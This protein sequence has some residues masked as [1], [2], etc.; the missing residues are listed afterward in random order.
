MI[1]DSD[2]PE[3]QRRGLP[4]TEDSL[5]Q[6]PSDRLKSDLRRVPSSG[7]RDS[8][9]TSCCP[10]CGLPTI[11]GPHSSDA[12]CVDA[13]GAEIARITIMLLDEREQRDRD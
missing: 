8:D 11:D 1:G 6:T 4:E 3:I 12:A 7:R 5:A 10:S 9:P 2:S 13:L